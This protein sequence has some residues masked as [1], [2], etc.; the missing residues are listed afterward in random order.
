MLQDYQISSHQTFANL[1]LSPELGTTQLK[2]VVVNVDVLSLIVV[3]D[4]IIL[5]CGQ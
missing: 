3:T 1:T 5:S 4:H 2:L